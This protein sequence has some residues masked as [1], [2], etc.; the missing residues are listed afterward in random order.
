MKNE[1]NNQK[2]N[3]FNNESLTNREREIVELLS[4]GLSNQ[5]MADYLYVS[6]RTIATHLESIY[7]KVCS[8]IKQD[9]HKTE[10]IRIK[11]ILRYLKYIGA[12]DSNWNIE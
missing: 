10:A 3:L 8:G 4:H 1:E 6:R 11:L 9:N 12:L 2:Q 7:R 5:Q